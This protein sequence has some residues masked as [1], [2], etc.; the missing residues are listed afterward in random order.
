MGTFDK[1]KDKQNRFDEYLDETLEPENLDYLTVICSTRS[2]S[3]A[4]KARSLIN[5]CQYAVALKIADRT[6]YNV[7]LNEF[8]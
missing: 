3:V 8:E 1:N 2:K 5:K 4:N 7:G 6:A